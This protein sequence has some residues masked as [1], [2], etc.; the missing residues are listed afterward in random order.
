MRFWDE[1]ALVGRH[2]LTHDVLRKLAF[3]WMPCPAR[4]PTP[5]AAKADPVPTH[6]RLGPDDCDNFRIDGS[7]PYGWIK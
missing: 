6:E 2:A 5:V 4:L 1:T 7:Q 3:P